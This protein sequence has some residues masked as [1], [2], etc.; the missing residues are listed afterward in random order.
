MASTRGRKRARAESIV[1]D[2]GQ[3]PDA[4]GKDGPNDTLE[5]EDTA[6]GVPRRYSTRH[7]TQVSHPGIAAGLAKRHKTDIQAEATKKK[8]DE[9]AKRE[10][11]EKREAAKAAREREGTKKLAAMLDER[12]REE[13]QQIQDMERTPSSDDDAR[14]RDAGS[15]ADEGA[16]D[17]KRRSIVVPNI[18]DDHHD[19]DLSDGPPGVELPRQSRSSPISISSYFPED[20][21]SSLSDS[22]DGIL[23][24]PVR[25]TKKGKDHKSSKAAKTSQNT[26]TTQSA[27]HNVGHALAVA[28]TKKKKVTETERR[29]SRIQKLRNEIASSREVAPTKTANMG[30]GHKP[31][32]ASRY[33]S[34]PHSM[35]S[36]YTISSVKI[37]CYQFQGES[38]CRRC[39]HGGFPDP[40]AHCAPYAGVEERIKSHEHRPQTHVHR[41]HAG[42]QRR[43][44]LAARRVGC[45]DVQLHPRHA[46][47]RCLRT[48]AAL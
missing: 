24:Q 16:N 2:S 3:N 20:S 32:G 36:T 21:D 19:D 34:R 10:K 44:A 42:I 39:I 22:D 31:A 8:A 48:H 1:S 17:G 47:L 41:G 40:R 45:N 18:D 37:R 11:K 13:L 7:S 30:L 38:R 4:L 35:L 23:E 12:A 5:G 29:V 9:A 25:P 43:C 33:V 6:P 28:P 15:L 27:T 14:A 46:H 26:K